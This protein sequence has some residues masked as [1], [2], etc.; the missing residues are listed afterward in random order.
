MSKEDQLLLAQAKIFKALGH[1]KRLRMAAALCSG[2][3]CVCTL[4]TL[5]DEDM[6]TVSRHLGV[7]RESGIISGR[8]RG[9]YMYYHLNMHCLQ[10]VLGCT[11]NM[12]LRS[13]LS[14]PPR[15]IK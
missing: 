7:L 5:V 9:T 11:E 3:Q 15:D 13:H 14:L 6:S 12:I 1:P 10:T 4:Q 2:E 8:K